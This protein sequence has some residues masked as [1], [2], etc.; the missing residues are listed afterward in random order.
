M[1]VA[2]DRGTQRFGITRCRRTASCYRGTAGCGSTLHMAAQPLS[3][4]G[5][6]GWRRMATA[7]H[8]FSLGQRPPCFS[9]P[10]GGGPRRACF[11]K[12][13]CSFTTPTA[14]AQGITQVHRRSLWLM[15]KETR[16][17]SDIAVCQ[18]ISSACARLL[19]GSP[20]ATAQWPSPQRVWRRRGSSS[21]GRWARL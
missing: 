8:S 2:R 10:S 18:D 12:G 1:S 14:S 9:K 3:A 7:R 6:A 19:P 4:P 21:P 16:I 15:E 17:T 11:S 20:P 13:A 5:C